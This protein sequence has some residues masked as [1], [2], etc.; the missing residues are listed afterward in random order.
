MQMY[1]EQMI[2]RTH[3]NSI[4]HTNQGEFFEHVFSPKGW[5][6]YTFPICS[7][8]VLYLF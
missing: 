7:E 2:I 4:A 6:K 3:K 8:H 5:P 1:I